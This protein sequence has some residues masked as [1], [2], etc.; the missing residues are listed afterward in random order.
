LVNKIFGR[1]STLL[2]SLEAGKK[3]AYRD[4]LAGIFGLFRNPYAHNDSIPDLAELDAVIAV[5]NLYLR[6]VGDF[7]LENDP[8][9]G[10]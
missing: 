7:R 8:S 6:I 3:Q 2:P 1:D 5:V 9:S 10:V 4:L